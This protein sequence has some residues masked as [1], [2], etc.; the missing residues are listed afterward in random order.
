[1]SFFISVIES[2]KIRMSFKHIIVTVDYTLDNVAHEMANILR[3]RGQICDIDD[4]RIGVHR[5]FEQAEKTDCDFIL[6]VSRLLS[7]INN[8]I[9]RENKT[10]TKVNEKQLRL[11]D[12]I[13]HIWVNSK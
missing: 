12:F 10:K 5:K 7:E 2:Y 4:R 9:V 6:V 1:M 13:H 8:V 3:E 11:I